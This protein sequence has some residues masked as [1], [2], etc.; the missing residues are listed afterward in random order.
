MLC[1][2]H[3]PAGREQRNAGHPL[4]V[5]LQVRKLQ[6]SLFIGIF[7][8]LSRHQCCSPTVKSIPLLK[9]D[10]QIPTFLLTGTLIFSTMS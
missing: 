9:S 1:A 4:V 2:D 6:S 7:E 5:L 8:I 10:G 3:I